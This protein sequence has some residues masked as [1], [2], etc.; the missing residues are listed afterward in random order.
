MKIVLIGYG[1]MGKA[2][3]EIVNADK[4]LDI[5]LIIDKDNVNELTKENLQKAD[6]AIEFTTPKTAVQN[7]H[8]CVD[9][10][11]P[12]V[13]GTTGW[14][15]NLE[16]VTEYV[17]ANNGSIVHATNFSIGVNIFFEIN[18]IL[19]EI[20][21]EQPQYDVAIEET[22]HT[23]KLD[24]P[25][26]TAITLA[27]RILSKLK[28]KNSWVNNKTSIKE[29]LEIISH[30]IENVP[31]THEVIYSSEADE[32]KLIHTANSRKGFAEGAI[33][34]A[35]WIKDKKGIFTMKDVLGI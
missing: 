3:E 13:V 8:T 27:E 16:A 31:G 1:K 5:V 17:L 15:D 9:A 26:G 4:N 18:K 33:L 10:G 11:I 32:I 19:A 28:T 14:Y 23:Q 6:V 12:V 7:I 25:S 22:H 35:K 20:M 21:R 24:A 29:E 34:A 2:I 30:R